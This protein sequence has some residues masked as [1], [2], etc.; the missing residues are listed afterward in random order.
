MRGKG[1]IEKV[2]SMVSEVPY[3]ADGSSILLEPCHQLC[4][5]P[6]KLHRA[7]YPPSTHEM[8]HPELEHIPKNTTSKDSSW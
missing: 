7:H 8:P 4:P 5:L 6:L 2:N 3:L 1:L